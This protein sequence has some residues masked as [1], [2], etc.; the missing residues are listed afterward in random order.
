MTETEVLSPTAKPIQPISDIWMPVAWDEYKALVSNPTYEKTKCYYLNGHMR[1]EMPPVSHDHAERDAT[2]TLAVNLFGITQ[3]IPFKVL[4][5]CTYRKS[6]VAEC[7]P[8]VSLY[9]GEQTHAVPFGTGIVHLETY[10]APDLV[11]EVAMSSLFDDLSVKRFLYES[12]GVKEYWVVDVEKTQITA[13]AIVEGG[14][15]PIRVSQVLPG[16][17][18]SIIEEA[19]YRSRETDQSQVGAWL[20]K[21]FQSMA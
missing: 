13:Y 16:L 18:L 20:L 21:Q 7:Q 19:L 14:S 5:N 8:D 4:G 6:G 1:L 15:K 11:I 2:I 9:V 17:D 12:L 10:P 3:E